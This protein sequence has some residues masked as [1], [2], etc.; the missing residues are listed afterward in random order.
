MQTNKKKSPKVGSES[1]APTS[2]FAY[3]NS[4]NRGSHFFNESPKTPYMETGYNGFLANKAFSMHY[5]S[6]LQANEMNMKHNLDNLLQ[7]E[8]LFSTVRPRSRGGIWYKSKKNEDLDAICEHFNINKN[9]GLNYLNL[10]SKSE[11][12]IIKNKGKADNGKGPI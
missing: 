6:I 8:Y 10:L 5:D 1:S 3:I 9:V 2:P 12:K 7:Y 4:I 11:I